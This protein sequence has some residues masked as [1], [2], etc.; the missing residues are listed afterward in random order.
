MYMLQVAMHG[1][2][3]KCVLSTLVYLANSWFL[4]LIPLKYVPKWTIICKAE[5]GYLLNQ[6]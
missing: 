4:P 2:V 6:N 1:A 5:S 3:L